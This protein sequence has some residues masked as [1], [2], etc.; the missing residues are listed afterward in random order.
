MEKFKVIAPSYVFPSLDEE[1]GQDFEPYLT[2]SL[3]DEMGTFKAYHEDEKGNF[4][5]PTTKGARKILSKIVISEKQLNNEIRKPMGL[6]TVDNIL[7]EAEKLE[8]LS[9]ATLTAVVPFKRKNDTFIATK[10]T[11]EVWDE[12]KKKWIPA[13]PDKEYK[14]QRNNHRIDYNEPVIFTFN[15]TVVNRIAREI[16]MEQ[17]QMIAK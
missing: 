2:I 15:Q 8:L 6:Q 13:V 1:K 11:N 3:Q 14:V 10:F 17:A 9:S 12:D 16:K 5:A 4:V 7:T